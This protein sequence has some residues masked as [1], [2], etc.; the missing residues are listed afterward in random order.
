M[1][2]LWGAK[3]KGMMNSRGWAVVNNRL[4]VTEDDVD[5][6][7]LYGLVVG[8][9]FI[10]Y[11][12]RT[13]EKQ[14]VDSCKS[15]NQLEKEL[16]EIERIYYT[17]DNTTCRMCDNIDTRCYVHTHETELEYNIRKWIDRRDGQ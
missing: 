15:V 2:F 11:M 4:V 8:W 7:I 5:T 17:S 12:R 3:R 1:K 9:H 6:F 13:K 10:G 16:S 14:F